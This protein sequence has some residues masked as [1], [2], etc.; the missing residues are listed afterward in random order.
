MADHNTTRKRSKQ[1][2]NRGPSH[3]KR[4]NRAAIAL[5]VRGATKGVWSV[6]LEDSRHA[7]PLHTRNKLCQNRKMCVRRTIFVNSISL[8]IHGA[9]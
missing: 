2:W 7:A 8:I 3:M 6:T 9:S 1:D 5:S 4:E